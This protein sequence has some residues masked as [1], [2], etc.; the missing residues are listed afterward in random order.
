MSGIQ[1][2]KEQGIT[3]RVTELE[4]KQRELVREKERKGV[5]VPCM[6]QAVT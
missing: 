5:A 6:Q 4:K 2:K 1:E 3:T